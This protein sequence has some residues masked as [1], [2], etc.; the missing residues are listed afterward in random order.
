MQFLK[1]L[2]CYKQIIIMVWRI[3]VQS[4]WLLFIKKE[5]LSVVKV[6]CMGVIFVLFIDG[7][8]VGH[9]FD[10]LSGGPIFPLFFLKHNIEE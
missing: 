1:L 7:I 6:F 3:G 9:K 4:Y 2:L 5:L 8:C 10:R